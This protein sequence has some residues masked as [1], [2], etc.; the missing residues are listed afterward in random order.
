MG[1]VKDLIYK[2]E[3][4]IVK[5]IEKTYWYNFNEDRIELKSVHTEFI[6]TAPRE[7]MDLVM[8]INSSMTEGE[9]LIELSSHNAKMMTCYATLT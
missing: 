6:E 7:A 1:K 8:E 2:S 5:I 9:E 3:T 4:V